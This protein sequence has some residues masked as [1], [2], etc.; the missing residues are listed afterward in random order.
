MKMIFESIVLINRCEGIKDKLLKNGCALIQQNEIQ[1][2]IF[3]SCI[4]NK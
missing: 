1:I 3:N 4:S 2:T